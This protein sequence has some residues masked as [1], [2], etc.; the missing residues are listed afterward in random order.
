M[1]EPDPETIEAQ[2]AAHR[3]TLA[4][5]LKQATFFSASQLVADIAHAIDATRAEIERLKAMLRKR[6]ISVVDEANDA[7]LRAAGGD[8]VIGDQYN[9][10]TQGGDYAERDIDRRQGVFVEGGTIYGPVIG[11]NWG[12]VT[13]TYTLHQRLLCH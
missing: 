13:T 12:S 4:G 11:V 1:N 5:L 9:V 6:G 10:T 8:V 2:L 7:A 3:R